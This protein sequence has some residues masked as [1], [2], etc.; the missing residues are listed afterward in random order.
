[1]AIN[2]NTGG[3]FAQNYAGGLQGKQAFGQAL[4]QG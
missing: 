4:G 2:Y 1:M 3:N